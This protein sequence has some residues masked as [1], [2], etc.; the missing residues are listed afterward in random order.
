[1]RQATNATWEQAPS[2]GPIPARLARTLRSPCVFVVAPSGAGKSTLLR[3]LGNSFDG[4]FVPCVLRSQHPA[5]AELD[6]MIDAAMSTD[7]TMIAIDDAHHVFG[8]H[9]EASLERLIARSGR[10]CHVVISSRLRFGR[11]LACASHGEVEVVTASDLTLRIDEIAETF[12]YV[13]GHALGLECASR[14]ASETGGWAALVHDLAARSRLVDPD[15]LESTVDAVLRGDF[16]ATR[17]EDAL[18]TLPGSIRLALEGT[19]G[20]PALEWTECTRL[21]GA[22]DATDLLSAV[23]SGEVMHVVE[24]GVRIV[25]PLLRRHLLARSGISAVMANAARTPRAGAARTIIGPI[26]PPAARFPDPFDA[27]VARLRGGDVMG[28][29]SLLQRALRRDETPAQPMA[30]LALLVIRESL[31]PRETTLDALAGLERE[32]V[33]RGPDG[34]DRVVRG[35][36]AAISELPDRAAQRVIEEC[37]VRGDDQAAALVAGIDFLVRMRRRR[38]TIAQAT[39]LAQRLDRLGFAD[40]A[41]WARAFGALLAA[42]SGSPQTRDLITDAETA[43]IATGIDGV[44][45]LIDAAGALAASDGRTAELMASSRR[46]AL[47]AGLPRLP[48]TLPRSAPASARAVAGTMS[49]HVDPRHPHLTVGCFG[50]FHLRADGAEIDLRAVRPQARAL[51]RMLALNSGSPLH[52]ELIADILW[53]DLGT[54]A[55]VHALHVSVSSLRRALPIQLNGPAGTIVERVGEAYRLGILDRRDC[56]LAEFDD[57]LA[58]AASSKLR[59]DAPTTANGLRRALTLYTGDVLPEDGPAEWVTGAR[60]RYRVRAAEAA[61]SLAHLELHLGERRAAVAAASRAVEIDPWLDESWRTLVTVHR[62]LGDVVAARRADE[63]YHRM[64]IALG[65]D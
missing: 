2:P 1:M 6:A 45:A 39:A 53:G 63:D 64:R 37:E 57:R 40:V 36:I 60:E 56:D 42:A 29:V 14:V 28:A 11:D 31:V 13:G 61:S 7:A 18:R 15:A 41:A 62:S 54:H 21:V 50:G 16:A 8:T 43:A 48:F 23:D 20:L 5:P 27:A 4:T 65:V 22:D 58:E 34:L 17:L 52:R 55:A 46:R 30:R 59:R 24:R 3:R 9:G 12:R 33:T 49:A 10:S 25:P 47:Q 26:T 51:L 44:R 19:S 35:A 32:C 38:A